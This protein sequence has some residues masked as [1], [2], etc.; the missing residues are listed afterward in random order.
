MMSCEVIKNRK[1]FKLVSRV[2][3]FVKTGNLGFWSKKANSKFVFDYYV[4]MTSQTP[5][6]DTHF[7]MAINRAFRCLYVY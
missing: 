3:D 6:D 5:Y 2:L 1:L 4:I 7:G